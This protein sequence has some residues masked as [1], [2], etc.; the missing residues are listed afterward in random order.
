MEILIILTLIYCLFAPSAQEYEE[1][2]DNE[3]WRGL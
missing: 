1:Y 2:R 3:K